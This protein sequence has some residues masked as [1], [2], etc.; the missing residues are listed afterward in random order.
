MNNNEA[1]L[2]FEALDWSPLKRELIELAIKS[3]IC[4]FGC[5]GLVNTRS[6]WEAH[7]HRHWT[8]KTGVESP[9]DDDVWNCYRSS[10][11]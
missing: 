9:G 4:P 5:K 11:K 6:G 2:M 1:N 7:I 3:K 10:S 8:D